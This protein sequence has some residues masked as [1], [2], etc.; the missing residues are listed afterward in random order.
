VAQARLRTARNDKFKG[1]TGSAKAEPLKA[2]RE[3]DF[4]RN[5][6]SRVL[7]TIDL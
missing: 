5:L 4:F 6:F 3:F 1:L 2:R 7:P